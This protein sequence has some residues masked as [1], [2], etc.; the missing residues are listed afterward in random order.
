MVEMK[1]TYGYW[2]V[3]GPAPG[4]GRRRWEC[5]CRCGTV[6]AVSENHLRS[7]ASHSCGCSRSGIKP[8]DVFGFLTVEGKGGRDKFRNQLW[9]CRCQCGKVILATSNA[10]LKKGKVLCEK[11]AHSLDQ[12]DGGGGGSPAPYK[13]PA[14]GKGR[15]EEGAAGRR[16]AW[17]PR[18]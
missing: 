9:R 16:A 18:G 7:Q 4:P 5:R 3:L 13:R 12:K 2:E 11:T 14:C 1:K 6:R 10:L 15:A 17:R 8:G